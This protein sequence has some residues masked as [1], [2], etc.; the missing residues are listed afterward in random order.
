VEVNQG[1][2]V[3]RSLSVWQLVGLSFPETKNEKQN[4]LKAAQAAAV[5][6]K[7]QTGKSV[8]HGHV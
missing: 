6:K 5:Q 8:L 2:A 4:T 1:F 3:R 7:G